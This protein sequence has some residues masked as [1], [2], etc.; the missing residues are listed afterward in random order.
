MA[1]VISFCCLRVG[2]PK[3]LGGDPVKAKGLFK[4]LINK[5]PHNW[6]ARIAYLRFYVIP[7]VDEEEFKREMD[8]LKKCVRNI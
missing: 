5:Y 7:M 4:A 1:L 2:R 6:L 3:M 8:Y